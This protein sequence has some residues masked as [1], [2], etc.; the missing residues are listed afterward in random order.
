MKTFS[1]IFIATILYMGISVQGQYE[2]AMKASLEKFGSA[3]STDELIA[4]AS[5]FERIAEA[6]P[7]QWLP[8]Y[9]SSLIYC[10]VTFRTEETE[11]KEDLLKQAQVMLDKSLEVAPK[12]SE[13]HAMQGMIYQAYMTIDPAR[14]GQIYSPKANGALETA[15]KLN[16]ENPRPYYLQAVS[17]MYTPKE[18]GGGKHAAL[19][20]FEKALVLFN[21]QSS[22][23][24]FYPDWGKEDCERNIQACKDEETGL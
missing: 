4:A 18:Y 13:L 24:A 2:E 14:N 20:L 23:Q 22:D 10:I 1:M 6:E 8:G 12:E 5:Q 15:I 11:K 21:E 19:P 9:Y 17:I 7:E 16:A 3:G